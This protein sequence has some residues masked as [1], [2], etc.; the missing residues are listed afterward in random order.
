MTEIRAMTI[1]DYDDA[2]ALW[3]VTKGMGLSAADSR[4]AI[5]H[6]LER[7]PGLSF[8]ARLEGG[9][10][11]GA[12][13]CGHDGRRGYL[14]HLAVRPDCRKQGLGRELADH[15]LAA[16]RAEGIDKCHVFVRRS[17]VAGQSFW[18]RTGWIERNLVLM[19][20][21]LEGSKG[22]EP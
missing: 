19:S 6:Y 2:M 20:R 12:V 4:E 3:Q 5:S 16:L 22:H 17:N 9:E 14:Y 18:Q 10:L 11:A 8:V 21:D 13:L 15:C 7:N 1:A